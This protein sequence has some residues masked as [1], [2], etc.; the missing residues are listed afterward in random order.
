MHIIE[1][2]AIGKFNTLSEF[3]EGYPVEIAIK[4]S[5][6]GHV[7]FPW[8]RGLWRRTSENILSTRNSLCSG[9]VVGL[10]KAL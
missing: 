7:R 3:R 8:F 10:R 5:S 4:M 2:N 6:K 9:P 1:L